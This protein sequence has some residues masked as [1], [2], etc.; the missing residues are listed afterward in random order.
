MG[1]TRN[2][3]A[4]SGLRNAAANWR[5]V[6]ARR[7]TTGAATQRP[8]TGGAGPTEPPR[9]EALSCAEL[10][11]SEA[12]PT[13]RSPAAAS[14]TGP[15][16]RARSNKAAATAARSAS[17]PAAC[18]TCST[19]CEGNLSQHLPLEPTFQWAK[20]DEFQHQA[21]ASAIPRGVPEPSQIGAGRLL[22]MFVGA[23][24]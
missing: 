17:T 24:R 4:K 14:A 3:A 21:I 16:A 18:A 20:S 13:S 5:N 12:R 23:A 15:A 2:A 7:P 19:T 11:M 10:R 8:E 22:G 1:M 9:V 6:C